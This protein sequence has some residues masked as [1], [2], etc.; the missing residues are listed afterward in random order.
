MYIRHGKR[1]MCTPRGTLYIMQA[2]KYIYTMHTKT[3]MHTPDCK[4]IIFTITPYTI[5]DTC[6]TYNSHAVRFMIIH[7]HANTC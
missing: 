3:Y 1:C 5:G 4:K 2:K 7:H 6:T